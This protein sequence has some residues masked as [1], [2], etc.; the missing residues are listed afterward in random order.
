MSTRRPSKIIQKMKLSQ[1]KRQTQEWLG[2]LC[3]FSH[4][5]VKLLLTPF[6]IFVVFNSPQGEKLPSLSKSINDV[7]MLIQ[8]KNTLLLPDRWNFVASW[9]IKTLC[10]MMTCL[11]LKKIWRLMICIA[12]RSPRELHSLLLPKVSGEQPRVEEHHPATFTDSFLKSEENSKAKPASVSNFSR[13]FPDSVFRLNLSGHFSK[14]DCENLGQ[15]D[16]RFCV[17]IKPP[18]WM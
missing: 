14:M 4:Q 6:F 15:K 9:K 16:E 1:E 2:T 10:K 17:R 13:W 7:Q 3:L 11:K 5:C 18:F 8:R 12:K